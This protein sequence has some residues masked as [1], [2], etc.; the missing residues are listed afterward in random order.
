MARACA[1]DFTLDFRSSGNKIGAVSARKTLQRTAGGAQ[2][3]GPRRK[4][5]DDVR[6]DPTSIDDFG[7]NTLIAAECERL[8][9]FVRKECPGL[10]PAAP[11]PAGTVA[12]AID[13]NADQAVRLFPAAA[14]IAAGIDPLST[15]PAPALVKWQEGDRE[16]VI[17]P[18]K[19][20][21]RF[22]NGVIAVMI[23][24]STDQTGD[25]AV[26]VSFVVGSPKQPAGLVA[27]TSA[28]PNGPAVIVDS[29]SKPLIAFAW[30]VVLE[31]ATNLAAAA[32]RDVDGSRLVPIALA[33]SPNAL[34]IVP[35]ARH[36]FDRRRG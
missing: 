5:R 27:T 16:L 26:F 6:R 15:A 3:V 18:S 4:A 29:W 22:A 19:V 23:A 1:L 33:A 17:Y 2:K 11:L 28:R 32:G 25:A 14:A 9:A 31:V 34:S 13:I 30:H 12:P 36:T 35:M 8:L 21:A 20:S 7:V 10:L 24:V